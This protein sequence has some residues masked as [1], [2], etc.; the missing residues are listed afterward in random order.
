M[1]SLRSPLIA[2]HHSVSSLDDLAAKPRQA[3]GI[4]TQLVMKTRH[5]V[6]F[7][8]GNQRLPLRSGDFLCADDRSQAEFPLITLESEG[9][10]RWEGR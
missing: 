3:R 7:A 10:A 2:E 8:P 4:S 5:T 9:D 6:H 1:I